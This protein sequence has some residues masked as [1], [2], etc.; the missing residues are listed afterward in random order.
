VLAAVV[1]V[2]PE[3]VDQPRNIARGS[4]PKAWN[5]VPERSAPKL[6]LAAR[7]RFDLNAISANP[8]ASSAKSRHGRHPR[9]ARLRR[10]RR[11]PGHASGNVDLPAILGTLRGAGNRI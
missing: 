10:G 4:G 7:A 3:P 8:Y 9:G 2:P 5:S 11:G 6:S 1:P